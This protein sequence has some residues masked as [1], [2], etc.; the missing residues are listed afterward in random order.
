MWAG[1]NIVVDFG[2]WT[3]ILPLIHMEEQDLQRLRCAFI[4]P[5]PE[6]DPGSESRDHPEQVERFVRGQCLHPPVQKHRGQCDEEEYK[7]EP[8][9]KEHPHDATHQK[10]RKYPNVPGTDRHLVPIQLVGPLGQLMAVDVAEYVRS[11]G[12]RG[13]QMIERLFQGAIRSWK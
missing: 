7:G 10:A 13:T 6:T 4:G 5:Y 2:S 11:P 3:L 1:Y 9:R 12:D 8:P